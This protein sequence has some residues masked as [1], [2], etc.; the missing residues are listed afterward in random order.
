MRDSFWTQQFI[1]GSWQLGDSSRTLEVR[2]PFTRDVITTFNIASTSQLD[3]AYEAAA[4]AQQ[5]WAKQSPQAKRMV[6][7]RAWQWVE[8]HHDE[9]I[10]II[11]SELGGTRLKAEVELSLVTEFLRESSA[12][13][14]RMDGKIFPSPSFEKEN[15][16]YREAAGVVGVI[17]PFNF[18]FI[19]AIRS[20]APALALG[21][22]VVLKP[23]ELAPIMG[24]TLIAR[25]FEECGLP[26]GVLNVVVT[27]IEEIGD[28]FIE[29]PVPEV[30]SF[31]GSTPVGSHIA[32]VAGKHLKRV[33]LELGGNN[34]FV[35]LDDADIDLA[36]NAA[37]FSRFTHA[38]QICMC[39][40]RLIVETGIYDEFLNK[41]LTKVQ[42]LTVGDPRNPD[43]IIGPLISP[44]AASD[45]D[46]QVQAAIK[47]GATA[48]VEPRQLPE[49]SGLYHPVVLTDVKPEMQVSQVELFGPVSCIMKAKDDED[50]IRLANATPYGLSGAV[51]SRN[52]DRATQVARRMHT[53][54]V[55]IN[56]TTIDD[57]FPAPFGGVGASG[58]SRLN[59]EWAVDAFTKMQW[60]SV[61]RGTPQ[62][63]Y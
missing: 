58:S 5:E 55:H 3:A 41:Y 28:H 17:V 36:V 48:A 49:N 30:I 22:A 53:G 39:A 46:K 42:S 54:M 34:A 47:E 44:K 33:I 32:E 38:G 8:S 62:F 26:A 61:H 19:L 56:D 52:I 14:T 35:V 4:K 15:R 37:V 11:T 13:P 43:T 1:N 2:D 40:G 23:H 50:A 63:P 18:P 24:G 6:F 16:A 12:L 59:G 27:D 31:T 25:I 29:H 7:E 51:H 60:V 20:V 57:E 9:L 21:N 45:L 10:D